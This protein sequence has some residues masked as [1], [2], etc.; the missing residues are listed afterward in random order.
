MALLNKAWA[1]LSGYRGALKAIFF[2][3][4]STLLGAALAFLTQVVLG[5]SLGTEQFGLFSSALALVL[6]LVPLAGLGVS[7]LWLKLFGEEG[8]SAIRWLPASFRLLMFSIALTVTLLL[9][10]ALWLPHDHVMRWLYLLLLLHLPAQVVIELLASRYQLEENYRALALWQFWPHASRLLLLV[11]LLL[12]PL[13]T[14]WPD[15]SEAPTTHDPLLNLYQVASVYA[16][17]ALL[18]LCWGVRRLYAMSK[19]NFQLKGHPL[20]TDYMT[21]ASQSVTPLPSYRQVLALTWPYGL[22]SLLYL[23]YFQSGV[24]VVHQ[25]LGAE[26]AGLYNAAF[27]I[28]ASVYLLPSVIYQK[29]LLPKIHRWAAQTPQALRQYYHR[30]N[31]LMLVLGLGAGVSIALSAFW[32]LPLL[33][34]IAYRDAVDILMILAIAAPFRFTATSVGAMLVTGDNMRRKVLCMALVALVYLLLSL[35]LLPMIGLIGAAI[36]AVIS[37]GLLLALYLWAVNRYVFHPAS[38]VPKAS[39]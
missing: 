11:V 10:W 37:D 38:Q 17:V 7:Q 16:L 39:L 21:S 35:T 26:P 24:V 34:G 8:W 31:R 33:F 28:M 25:L 18:F 32:V 12:S 30:G 3:W 20:Q 4:S 2:L 15:A 1:L 14:V 13:W 22:G 23:L 5:R 36:A 27:V 19:G 9:V 6:L 29:Y